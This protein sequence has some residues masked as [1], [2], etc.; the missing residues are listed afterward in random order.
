VSWV[1]GGA[2]GRL[3]F[4]PDVRVMVVSD[5]RDMMYMMRMCIVERF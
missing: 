5:L 3:T 4:S 2:G 1:C